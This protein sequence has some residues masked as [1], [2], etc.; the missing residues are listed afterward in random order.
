MKKPFFMYAD[1][2]GFIETPIWNG[3]QFKFSNWVPQD[4]AFIVGQPNEKGVRQI[5]IIKNIRPPTRDKRR[6]MTEK[7]LEERLRAEVKSKTIGSNEYV[8][9]H[10]MPIIQEYVQQFQPKGGEKNGS[11]KT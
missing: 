3:I 7:E 8:V 6:N 4:M 11:H 2:K 10:L 1:Q 9:N 5:E